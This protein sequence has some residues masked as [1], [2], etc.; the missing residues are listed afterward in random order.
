MYDFLNKATESESV[1]SLW[2]RPAQSAADYASNCEEHFMLLKLQRAD[3]G[4]Q[5]LPE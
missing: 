4:S 2:I 1:A 5:L 3:L